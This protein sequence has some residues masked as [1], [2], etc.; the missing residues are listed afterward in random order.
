M[1][2]LQTANPD[3]YPIVGITESTARDVVTNSTE[4]ER[5]GPGDFVPT[6]RK[7]TTPISCNIISESLY[8]RKT[9]ITTIVKVWVAPPWG[10]GWELHD[11]T[12]ATSTC[13]RLNVLYTLNPLTSRRKK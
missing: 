3:L 12:G 10:T 8:A 5:L 1:Y 7:S 4:R 13:C 6:R 11:A 9:K 2:L